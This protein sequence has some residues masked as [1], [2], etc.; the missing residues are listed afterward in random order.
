MK[1]VILAGGFG[2]RLRPLTNEIPKPMIKVNDKPIIGWQIEWLK[3]NGINDIVI[4]AGYK[5]EHIIDYLKDGK[6]LSI[7]VEYVIEEEPLDTGGGLKN[8]KEA[9]KEERSFLVINGDILTNL[10]IDD[11]QNITDCIGVL[12]VVPLPSPF[13]IVNIDD[14][15]NILGFVE[16]PKIMDYW[17]NAGVYYLKNEIFDY[18]PDVG[19]IEKITFPKLA[20]ERK[21]KAVKYPDVYWRSIDSHK[22]IEEATKDLK[23]LG[24]LA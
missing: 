9:L 22:D 20:D 21:L 14:M 10:K 8:A 13:G 12:A 2:K 11:M 3:A 17:I 23:E 1:A 15:Q 6:E 24:S 7:N 5:R 19:S 18:L 16:K 4:A